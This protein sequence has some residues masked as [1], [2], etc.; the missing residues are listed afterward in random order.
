MP[1]KV[2]IRALGWPVH[3]FHVLIY[4]KSHSCPGI[5]WWSIILNQHKVIAK[6]APCLPEHLWSNMISCCRTLDQSCQHMFCCVF[7]CLGSRRYQ[8]S[9]IRSRLLVKYHHHLSV[10]LTRNGILACHYL[11]ITQNYWV[12]ICRQ[13][14]QRITAFKHIIYE[15]QLPRTIL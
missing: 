5:E 8:C 7:A 1:N 13:L 3:D 14:A 6:G 15:W 12:Y 4:E 9:S 10:S 11:W 2:N